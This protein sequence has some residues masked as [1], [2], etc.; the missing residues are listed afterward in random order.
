M[1][2][3][4]R[5]PFRDAIPVY[6]E[7][8]E[9]EGFQLADYWRAIRKSLW[10]VVGIAVLVTTLA[11]IYMARKPNIYQAK[12]IVQV[13][14][15]QANPD[16]LSNGRASRVCLPSGRIP[17]ILIPSSTAYQREPAEKGC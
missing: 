17:R 10:L 7:T 4:L 14:L 6:R 8:A 12:A 13:D 1:N 11:A 3:R 16:L 9:K 5:R 2:T 15:E